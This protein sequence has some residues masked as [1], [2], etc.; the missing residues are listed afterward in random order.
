MNMYYKY[1]II[2][3]SWFITHQLILYYLVITII[4]HQPIW[5]Y[6]ILII[7]YS[8]T[9]FCIIWSSVYYL[10][11]IVSVCFYFCSHFRFHHIF[12]FFMA[13]ANAI[14]LSPK[15]Y[16]LLLINT[17]RIISSSL[18]FTT[19]HHSFFFLFF[20]LL[21]HTSLLMA[22]ANAMYHPSFI[23]YYSSTHYLFN[24]IFSST[25]LFS[26]LDGWC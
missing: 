21:P 4:T 22:D 18:L 23:I 2:S 15:S 16:Y 26:F 13:D 11:L 3:L 6:L 5:Y 1:N 8:S 20:F 19:H 10:L 17:L 7:Y 25:H 12:H 14:Y 24:F 9:H